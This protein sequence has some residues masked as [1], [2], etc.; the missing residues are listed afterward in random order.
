MASTQPKTVAI[1]DDATGGAAAPGTADAGFDLARGGW[2]TELSSMWPGMGM[3]LQVEEVV[4]KG[5]SDFQVREGERA[6][7]KGG[8]RER[9]GSKETDPAARSERGAQSPS[10][11]PSSRAPS[12]L[13]LS[14]L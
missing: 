10:F 11:N 7:E 3:S 2:Y 4:F 9:E 5:K 1:T 14:P 8:R 13:S 6:G 12:P